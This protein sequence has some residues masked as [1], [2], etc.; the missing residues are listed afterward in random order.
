MQINYYEILGC[1]KDSTYEEIKR[2]YHVRLLQ[3]HPDKKQANT[4]SSEFYNVREAWQVL[5]NSKSRREYDL[6]CK[7]QELENEGDLVYAYVSPNELETT[8]DEDRLFY[9]CKCGDTYNIQR[10]Q[11]QEKN[12][13]LHVTCQGCTL[14]IVIET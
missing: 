14:T 5:G 6:A 4:H 10:E 9:R 13:M 12:T 7:Q 3:L 2:A 11:L 8:S 1:N